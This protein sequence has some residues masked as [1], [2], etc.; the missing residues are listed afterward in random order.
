MGANPGGLTRRT[1]PGSAG[2]DDA[3]RAGAQ[4]AVAAR[5]GELA[6]LDLDARVRRWQRTGD[7]G[8][9]WPDFDTRSLSA[10]A[11][12]IERSVTRLLD[13]RVASLGAPDGNDARAIGIAALLSGTGPL[14]G[15]WVEQGHLDVAPALAR[16]LERHLTHGRGRTARIRRAI[17]PALEDLVRAGVTPTVL[18]GLHTGHVYF[19]EPGVRPLADVDAYVTPDAAAR[20]EQVLLANGF[21]P[22]DEG[23]R[24]KRDWYPS[25]GST[26]IRSFEFWHV[27][28]PWK[29][30][31]HQALELGTL[32]RHRVRLEEMTPL[33]APWDGLGVALHVVP[34]PLRLVVHAVHL[35]SELTS[36]RLLRLVEMI[37]MVRRDTASGAL[38]WSAAMD[39]LARTGAMRFA[40]PALGLAE[41]LAPGTIPGELV[42]RAHQ[43]S[44]PI[45]RSVVA[46]L[47][48]ATP[49]LHD[50]VAFSERLMWEPGALGIARRV[51][52]M[53][54]PTPGVPWRKGLLIYRSRL[55]RL[56]TGRISWGLGRRPRSSREVRT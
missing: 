37:L 56:V 26:R 44:T 38:D 15:Y 16:V 45:A 28:S 17:T 30:E 48:P 4:A 33:T 31:L 42:A 40:Y 34:Q 8:S 1:Q 53:F 52:E 39:L 41:Q 50:R 19:P 22:G 6:P 2:G 11:L 14:L 21:Q 36:A 29:L 12:G 3:G 9:L 7:H 25:R 43:R 24:F 35:S 46:R 49:I 20:A 27:R 18:K 51:V 32:I 47:T 55:S 54:L 5:E 10:A 23:G 13:G